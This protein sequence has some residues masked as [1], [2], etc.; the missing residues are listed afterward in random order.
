MQGFSGQ[1][2]SYISIKGLVSFSYYQARVLVSTYEYLSQ[3]SIKTLINQ[4]QLFN[5]LSL[6]RLKPALREISAFHPIMAHLST[7]AL[8]T[9]LFPYKEQN[10]HPGEAAVVS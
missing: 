3:P 5:S 6:H 1:H 2:H 7:I 9:C 10:P 8:S 4:P